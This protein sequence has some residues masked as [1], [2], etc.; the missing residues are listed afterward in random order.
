MR[1]FKEKAM[2][3]FKIL[4]II[5]L[6]AAF[7]AFPALAAENINPDNDDSKYAWSEN[8]GWINAEPMGE[9]GPGAEVA[10]DKITGYIWSENIGWISLSC[11]N[12]GSCGTVDYGVTNDG[13]GN[14]SGYGWSENAGWINFSCENNGY[15]PTVDY[16]VKIDSSTG[17][18][19]G[20]AWAENI[21]W[22]KFA[23]AAPFAYKVKTSWLSAI[24]LP[25][26]IS[27]W[28]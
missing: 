7:M 16:G 1:Y 18:F 10:D 28:K 17:D 20:Y 26:F 21:G 23:K 24:A 13:N 15:C 19:S 4:F 2:K 8:A 5:A 3:N 22:I 11:E 14:L 6:L 27:I 25:C 9:A 12:K